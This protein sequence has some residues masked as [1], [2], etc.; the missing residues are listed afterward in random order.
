MNRYFMLPKDRAE[1]NGGIILICVMLQINNQQAVFTFEEFEQYISRDIYKAYKIITQKEQIHF[2]DNLM[3]NWNTYSPQS[4]S[5]S[6]F[7]TAVCNEEDLPYSVYYIDIN[8]SRLRMA[9]Y[10]L[11]HYSKL[12]YE[13][14][15]EII[16]KKLTMKNTKI[17]ITELDTQEA[18]E[19]QA[20]VIVLYKEKVLSAARTVYD[21]IITS[22]KEG[23]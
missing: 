15:R 14:I 17:E 7:I 3:Y 10:A 22:I 16:I 8:L 2:Y 13:R 5:N 12:E 9:E 21:K 19:L 18:I 6:C 11:Y 20:E 4:E 23:T 1:S